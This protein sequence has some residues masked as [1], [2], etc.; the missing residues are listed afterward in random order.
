M[1]PRYY[2]YGS[3]LETAACKFLVWLIIMRKSPK[4]NHKFVCNKRRNADTEEGKCMRYTRRMHQRQ[5]SIFPSSVFIYDE[6]AWSRGGGSIAAS[7]EPSGE[8]G[9]PR[10]ADFLLCFL[11]SYSC[12]A[13]RTEPNQINLLLLLSLSSCC[14]SPTFSSSNKTLRQ[15]PLSTSFWSRLFDWYNF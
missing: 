9:A 12:L 7:A 15:N 10:C 8:H 3:L 2:V 5:L 6:W 4:L 13:G 11:S 14:G 1:P